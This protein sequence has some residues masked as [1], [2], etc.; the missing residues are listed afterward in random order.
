MY[1]EGGWKREEDGHCSHCAGVSSL[2]GGVIVTWGC[3]HHVGVDS[4]CGGALLTQGWCGHHG[5]RLFVGG[6]LLGR[7]VETKVGQGVLT[8]VLSY[9][10]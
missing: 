6:T 5:S 2:H 10:Q 1:R 8:F 3:P 7:G 4:S 9:K